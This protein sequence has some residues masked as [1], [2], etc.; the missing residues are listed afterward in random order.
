MKSILM[1]ILLAILVNILISYKFEKKVYANTSRVTI[2]KA[3]PTITQAHRAK[4]QPIPSISYISSSIGA[5]KGRASFYTNDYCRKFNPRC[6]TAS[7]E[8]FDD[9][10]FTAACSKRFALGSTLTVKH[11]NASIQVKCNDRG[12]FNEKYGRILD[13]SKAAFKALSPLS[14]GVIEVEVIH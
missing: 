11:G 8:V 1:G 5:I 14:K 4:V 12:S 13:L 6:L 7:G 9:T 10:K 2:Q 3:K